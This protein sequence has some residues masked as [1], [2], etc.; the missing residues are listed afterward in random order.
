MSVEAITRMEQWLTSIEADSAAGT[1]AE[2]TLRNRPVEL[3]DACWTSA[4]NRI[5]EPFGLAAAGTCETLYPTYGDTRRAAGSG[6]ANDTLKCQRQPLDL[7]S[8]G[9][10]AAQQA[11]LSTV[12]ATGVCD[13][14]QPGVGK[15]A[16]LGTWLDYR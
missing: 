13:W 10:T 12:F 8:S 6:L 5:S 15:V 14:T 1:A 11:R 3:T 7:T 16:P 9:F 4:T 2:R